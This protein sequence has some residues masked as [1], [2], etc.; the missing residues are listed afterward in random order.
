[1]QQHTVKSVR[2]KVLKLI[3]WKSSF[4]T[5]Q[6]KS[7]VDRLVVEVSRSLKTGHTQL[8]E[9][10]WRSDQL[11]EVTINHTQNK[12]K[13]RINMPSAGYEPAISA[14]KRLHT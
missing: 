9:L 14:I 10:A 2:G 1:M 6:H 12:H 7:V 8:A 5:Q 13:K 4:L 11:A 3:R